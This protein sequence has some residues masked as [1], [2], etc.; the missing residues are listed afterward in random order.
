EIDEARPADRQSERRSADGEA[1]L[2]R[3][4]RSEADEP[5]DQR[6]AHDDGG[7]KDDRNGPPQSCIRAAA[8]ALAICGPG[9]VYF[10]ILH[11]AGVFRVSDLRRA[12]TAEPDGGDRPSGLV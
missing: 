3:Q 1:R 12:R 8:L 7:S 5:C 4:P 9:L 10:A 6:E 2:R 11:L